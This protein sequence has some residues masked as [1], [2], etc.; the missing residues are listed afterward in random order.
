VQGALEA[1]RGRRARRAP[2]GPE[3]LV[4]E[5]ANALT[6]WRSRIE[7]LSGDLLLS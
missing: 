4:G 6:A 1:G 7:L 3:R 5:R 2:Q